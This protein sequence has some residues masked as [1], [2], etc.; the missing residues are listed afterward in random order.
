[1][2]LCQPGI[3]FQFRLHISGVGFYKLSKGHIQISSFFHTEMTF[4]FCRF[5]FGLKSPLNFP[6]IITSPVTIVK[7]HLLCSPLFVFIRCH[8]L[9]PF[10][11]GLRHAIKLF[12]IVFSAHSSGD[13]DKA[14]CFQLFVHLP[15]QLISK[16]FGNA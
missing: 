16:W 3:V 1:M 2:F 11:I 13:C 12:F 10:L 7:G 5:P 14:F 15:H 4:P 6:E 9:A 8:N